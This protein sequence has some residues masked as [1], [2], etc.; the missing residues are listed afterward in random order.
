MG[1]AVIDL[2]SVSGLN[3]MVAAQQHY[4]HD[5]HTDLLHPG[6]K[7]QQRIAQTLVRQLASLP[8]F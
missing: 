8:V 4:F 1:S 2:N 6:T 7:G 5:K 3:P